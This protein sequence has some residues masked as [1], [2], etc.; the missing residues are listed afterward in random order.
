M[1]ADSKSVYSD[2]GL[3]D[4]P[5]TEQVPTTASFEQTNSAEAGRRVYRPVPAEQRQ[6]TEYQIRRERNNRAVKRART[7]NK[8]KQQCLTIK[9]EGYRK[10]ASEYNDAAQRM[11]TERQVGRSWAFPIFTIKRKK[12]TLI[13]MSSVPN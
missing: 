8:V 6:S 5:K 11:L 10:L 12:N 9:A 3:F 13:I 2:P 1:D 7:N 4:N